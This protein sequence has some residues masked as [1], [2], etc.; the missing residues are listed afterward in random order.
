G[1]PDV[2]GVFFRYTY[3]R[4]DFF[5]LDVRYYRDPNKAPDTPQKTML[6][7]KQFK[8]LMSELENSQALFK[9]LV[10]GSG[11]SS[12]KGMGGDSWASF[13][14]ERNVLFDFIRDHEI[15]GVVLLSGDTHVGELNVIPWSDKGGYD[16]YD[17][18]SSPLAQPSTD[19]WLERRPERRI[20]PV[21]FSG[22]NFGVID[23][24]F[25]I[26]PELIFQLLDSEGRRVWAPFVL[27]AEELVNGVTSWPTKVDTQENQR[28]GNFEQGKGYYERRP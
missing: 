6:G 2:P 10:S 25:G 9:V 1:V 7:E 26:S 23:F 27:Q 14:N 21:F 15:T 28:Q 4:V 20:R 18:V 19:S 16:F 13:I 5:F 17:L 22:P 12:A 8:W 11:W 3:G 24:R